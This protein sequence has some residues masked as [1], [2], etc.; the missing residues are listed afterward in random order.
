M[1]QFLH[2]N[3]LE[4]LG[5]L[6][7]GIYRLKGYTELN[8]AALYKILRK[9]DKVLKRTDGVAEIY[10][11]I[12]EGTRIG[13]M[14]AIEALDANV[15]EVGPA[16]IFQAVASYKSRHFTRGC[17][18]EWMDSLLQQRAIEVLFSG[19]ERTEVQEDGQVYLFFPRMDIGPYTSQVRM[20]CQILQEKA[21]RA[22]VKVL[23]INPGLMKDGA[24][25]YLKEFEEL[26]E[27]K[28]EIQLR[29]QDDRRGGLRVY[30]QALQR[31][32]Y[33]MPTWFPIPDSVTEALLR[34]FI[35]QAMR[36]GHEEVFRTLEKEAK[37]AG[38]A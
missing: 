16:G 15:K 3:M 8:H 5:R 1:S 28:T 37:D 6:G 10:P 9:W 38:L 21:N 7:E 2:L 22:D 18:T 30:Q 34:T 36:A 26:L 14:T 29:W 17:S 13:D 24:I 4:A 31:F 11:Q 19:V 20:T 33:Y 12:I 25:E 27:A 35:S 32:K 23:A